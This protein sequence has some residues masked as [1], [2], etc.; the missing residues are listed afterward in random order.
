MS[1]LTFFNKKQSI[2]NVVNVNIGYHTS[3][4][5][6]FNTESGYLKIY[7]AFYLRNTHFR[8]VQLNRK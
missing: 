4:F 8:Y 2:V 6:E 3:L 1:H 5:L 7:R